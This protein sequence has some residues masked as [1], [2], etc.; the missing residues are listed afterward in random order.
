V[1]IRGPRKEQDFTILANAV[2]R[3]ERLSFKARGLLVFGLSQPPD[4]RMTRDELVAASS[5][6]GQKSVRSGLEELQAVGYLVRHRKRSE[7]GEFS[8]ESVLYDEPQEATESGIHTPPTTGGKGPVVPTRENTAKPQVA[9]SGPL[10]SMVK[11]PSSTK[12]C[13]EELE[14]LGSPNGSQP[15]PVPLRGSQYPDG[16]MPKELHVALAA[17]H[18]LDVDVEADQFEDFHRAKGSVFKDW[19]AAF[20]T[21]LRNSAKYS[22]PS[23]KLT[24]GGYIPEVV[25]YRD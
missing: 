3:D 12:Y 14:G 2:L 19:D 7:S 16:W 10:A 5:S 1:I 15:K 21:W 22:S 20:R 8:W 18:D 24:A 23:R 25:R 6:D 13:S 11:G 17:V 4:Y 9:A